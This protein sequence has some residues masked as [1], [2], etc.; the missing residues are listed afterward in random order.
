MKKFLVAVD[1]S[2]HSEKA[3]LEAKKLAEGLK[4]DLVIMN[5]MPEVTPDPYTVLI[6]DNLV[7]KG[8]EDKTLG[9]EEKILKTTTQAAKDVLEKSLVLFNDFKGDV[10]TLVAR[11]NT[12]DEII[13][14]AEKEDYDLI[15][16][17]SRGLGTFSRATVGSISEK[18]LNHVEKNVLIVK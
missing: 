10:K 16:M 9:F 8:N 1:G 18:V 15:I 13:K 5:V 6:Y 4:V 7:S 12:A 3:L 14:E 11:G 17:G 2:E